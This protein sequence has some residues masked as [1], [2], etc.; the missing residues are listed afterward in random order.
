VVTGSDVRKRDP[1]DAM[2]IAD[3]PVTADTPDTAD[4][5]AVAPPCPRRVAASVCAL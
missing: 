5:S 1:A 3:T 4:Q 2:D